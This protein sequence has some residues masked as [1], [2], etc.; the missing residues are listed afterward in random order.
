MATDNIYK[1]LRNAEQASLATR[2]QAVHLGADL[3]CQ[4][5]G[6]QGAL[7]A[8]ASPRNIVLHFCVG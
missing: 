1:P 8:R 7:P 5:E 3:E 2:L 6:N 4:R